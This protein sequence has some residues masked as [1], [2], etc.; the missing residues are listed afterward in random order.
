MKTTDRRRTSGTQETEAHIAA[1]PERPI[2]PEDQKFMRRLE[3][4]RNHAQRIVRKLN[5]LTK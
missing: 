5:L 2:H 1:F 4:E 3:R